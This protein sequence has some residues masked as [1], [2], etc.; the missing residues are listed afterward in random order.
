MTIT[1]AFWD[2]TKRRFAYFFI[3]LAFDLETLDVF[4]RVNLDFRIWEI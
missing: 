2:I 4:N 1:T 3:P